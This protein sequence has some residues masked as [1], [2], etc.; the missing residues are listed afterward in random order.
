MWAICDFFFIVLFDV[1]LESVADNRESGV[2]GQKFRDASGNITTK[3][4]VNE[5]TD[6]MKQYVKDEESASS[7]IAEVE[8]DMPHDDEI[9]SE[10]RRQEAEDSDYHPSSDSTGES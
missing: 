2:F 10:E 6:A 8:R 7:V 3:C 1:L 9:A 4:N 5:I